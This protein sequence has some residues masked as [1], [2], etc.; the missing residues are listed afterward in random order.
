MTTDP[1]QYAD[2]DHPRDEVSQAAADL[3]ISTDGIVSVQGWTGSIVVYVEL[4]GL[5]R[6]MGHKEALFRN[7]RG[8]E[9]AS[10]GTVDDRDEFSLTIRGQRLEGRWITK[11]NGTTYIVSAD[12]DISADAFTRIIVRG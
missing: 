10:D 2:A 9:W 6:I 11:V 4:D 7:G 3:N 5:H 12:A 8:T 1:E